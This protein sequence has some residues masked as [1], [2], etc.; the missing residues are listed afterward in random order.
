M[1]V[2]T[3]ALIWS[4]CA[5][6]AQAEATAELAAALPKMVGK[7]SEELERDFAD[8]L[9]KLDEDQRGPLR[10]SLRHVWHFTNPDKE[11]R[12]L[13]FSGRKLIIIPGDS[14]ATVRLFSA[15][16]KRLGS[17]DF[18]TGWRMDI[19]SAEFGSNKLL[20]APVIMITSEPMRGAG[21]F[22][23]Q[24]LSF[25]EDGLHLVRIE[26]QQGK[27]VRNHYL[28]PNFTL[29]PDV[30]GRTKEAWSADLTADSHVR[31]LAALTYLAGIHMDPERPREGVYSE[32]IEDAKVAREVRGDKV[33]KEAIEGYRKAESTWLKEAAEFAASA[34]GSNQ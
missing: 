30:S 31:R 19:R 1:K 17:W 10:P 18:S 16:G 23:R 13:L 21:Q 34:E 14:S 33:V 5:V 22:V 15:T 20:D 25:H 4:V 29:G 7:S 28:S 26:D 24:I 27:L 11:D 9:S 8:V 12:Y 32:S 2:L 6:V 3:I